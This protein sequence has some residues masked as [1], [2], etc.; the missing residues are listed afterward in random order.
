MVM[1][2]SGTDL[3]IACVRSICIWCYSIQNNSSSVEG[4]EVFRKMLEIFDFCIKIRLLGDL[5]LLGRNTL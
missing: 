3:C 1:C 5:I 4:Q 2:G